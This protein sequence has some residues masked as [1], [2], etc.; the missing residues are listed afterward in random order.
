MSTSARRQR[1][2]LA[3]VV[4]GAGLLGLVATAAWYL[5]QPRTT[6]QPLPTLEALNDGAPRFVFSING[7]RRPLGVALS[8]AGDRIY[9]TESDGDHETKV[10]DR[11]GTFVGA[12]HPPD[13]SPATRTPVYVA[14]SPTTGDVYVSDR[15]SGAIDVYTPAGEWKGTVSNPDD[16]NAAWAPLGLGFDEPGDLLVTDV[17][18]TGQRLLQLGPDGALQRRFDTE[19][20][21]SGPLAYP[22]GITADKEGR[23]LVADSNNGRVLV[24]APTG[25]LD[26]VIGRGG[27]GPTLGLPRGVAVD[28]HGRVFVVD[29]TNH[30]V[31]VYRLGES[32]DSTQLLGS[33]GDE[34]IGDGAFEFPNG[35]ALDRAARLYVADR[36]NDRVQV[37]TY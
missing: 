20:S 9:I 17:A 12:L 5:A 18:A 23:V 27:F 16:P 22:N 30:H 2:I 1:L 21:A 28:D 37:W 14:A 35:I 29:T 25:G 31:M 3:A 24:L 7:P 34:G 32:A 19:L 8:P 36:E 33:V 4:L 13:S 11:Q 10:Y 15:H 26:Q 6:A